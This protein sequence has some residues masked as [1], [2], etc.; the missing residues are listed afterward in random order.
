[1][2]E[3][4][5]NRRK[6]IIIIIINGASQRWRYFHCVRCVNARVLLVFLCT[7]TRQGFIWPSHIDGS[8]LLLNKRACKQCACVC[9]FAVKCT[10]GISYG[11]QYICTQFLT[12]DTTDNGR[13]GCAGDSC[14]RFCQL[15]AHW[16]MLSHRISTHACARSKNL[17]SPVMRLSMITQFCVVTPTAVIHAR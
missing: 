11:T 6:Q 4:K 14:H 8:G 12:T 9:K 5:T 7:V 15:V 10:S 3:S 13:F 17:M 16:S 1:M 2:Q